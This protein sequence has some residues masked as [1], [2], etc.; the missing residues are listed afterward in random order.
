MEPA[1]EQIGQMLLDRWGIAVKGKH[2]V[3]VGGGD[4][5]NDCTGS[6]I[7]L[8]AESVT[9]IEMMPCPPEKRASNNP[10][11]EWPKV[12]KVDYGAEESIAKFGH[13]PRIYETTVKE[14][15]NA[16]RRITGKTIPADD[17]ERRPGD[18]ACLYATSKRA[19]ELLGWE[20]KYSDV[21][22]LVKTTW[23]VYK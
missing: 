20:P 10:W 1:N 11:P 15:I 2:V 16:A 18:P 5:G 12:L 8:G 21:D 13:D 4:T 3:I 6:A 22:T 23:E 17:V 14:I 19:K 7:R 9:Q